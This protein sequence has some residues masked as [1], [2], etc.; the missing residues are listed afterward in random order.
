MTHIPVVE[1]PREQKVP[2]KL[3]SHLFFFFFFN[4]GCTWVFVV[5]YG[6]SLVVMNGSCFCCSAHASHCSGFSC[7]WLSSAS[8]H[9]G[10]SSCG[11]WVAHVMWNHLGPG[12]EPMSPALAGGFLSTIPWGMSLRSILRWVI[13]VDNSIHITSRPVYYRVTYRVGSG[14]QQSWSIHS[15]TAP[16]WSRCG[17]FIVNL[18]YGGL[19]LEVGSTFLSQD[20][21]MG[22]Q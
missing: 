1:G 15:Y 20:L 9:A 18:E 4:L 14:S 12:I 13:K 11:A 22:N 5:A 19:C 21:W 17:N 16:S 6:L 2:T 7:C 3:T 8:G 10:F